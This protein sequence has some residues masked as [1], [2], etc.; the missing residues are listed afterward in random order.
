MANRKDKYSLKR[1]I[2]NDFK[3][4]GNALR[5]IIIFGFLILGVDRGRRGSFVSR[6]NNSKYI[7][8]GDGHNLLGTMILTVEPGRGGGWEGGVGVI[9]L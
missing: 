2:K 4:M 6:N 3:K 9:G 1:C 8:Q 5:A 7:N